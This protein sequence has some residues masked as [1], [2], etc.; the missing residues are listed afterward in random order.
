MKFL[1]IFKRKK[2][3]AIK[4]NGFFGGSYAFFN[5][6]DFISETTA[7]QISTVFSCIRVLSESVG[8]LP[9]HLMK[10]DGKTRQKAFSHKLYHILHTAPNEE[11]NAI[12]FY[13]MIVIHLCL[14]GNFYAQILRN[15]KNEIIALYPLL[16]QNMQKYRLANGKII[17]T[18]HN[19]AKTYELNKKDIFE[20]MGLSID[21]FKGLSPIAYQA[22][23]LSFTQTAN[24]FNARYFKNAVTPPLAVKYPTQLSDEQYE[25]LRKS[26]DDAYGGDNSGKVVIAENGIDFQTLGISSQDGKFLETRQFQKSEICGIFRI[27][28]HLIADLSKSSFNN[29]SEMSLELVKYTLQPYLTRIEQAIK[30][31]L[32]N[33]DEQKEYY[34]KFN[35]EGL[36]R[37]DTKSRYEAYRVGRM[38]GFLSTNEIRAKEDLN[39]I[40]GGDDYL[41]PLN[42]MSVG[43]VANE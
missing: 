29:I 38:S 21:G 26:W 24:K 14:N 10:F 7:M 11:I 16:P 5:G 4:Q 43:A 17:F 19:G 25:K 8:I 12:S 3:Q 41:S 23:A 31:Q 13:E 15:N 42:M 33:K 35:V 34:A 22:S 18:Y 2:Q 20:V 37:G 36:L 40:D 39:P 27:P 28:P 1:N 32:L 30:T 9:M 6:D